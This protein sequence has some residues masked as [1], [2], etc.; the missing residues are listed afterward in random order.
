MRVEH[1]AIWTEDMERLVGFYE[2]YF[3]A[4]RN[5]KYR[6]NKD[7]E[8]YFL[9]F[10]EGARLEIMKKP[11]LNNS[12]DKDC[13]GYTHVAFSVGNREKVISLTRELEDDG[14]KVLSNPRTTGDGYFES[15]IQDPDGNIIEITV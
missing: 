7:F 11:T 8:S 4:K 15:V 14:Y 6:N 9:Q 13:I 5:D 1:I 10:D 3:N 12:L 2:K